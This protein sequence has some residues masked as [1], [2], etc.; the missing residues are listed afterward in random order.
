MRFRLMQ[1]KGCN[2][3][4]SIQILAEGFLDVVLPR[5]L[6]ISYKL[7]ICSCYLSFLTHLASS[8]FSLPVD[9]LTPAYAQVYKDHNHGTALSTHPGSQPPRAQTHAPRFVTVCAAAPRLPSAKPSNEG[10]CPREPV[11]DETGGGV[12]V[13]RLGD[14]KEITPLPQAK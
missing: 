4:G 7:N 9:F 1:G 8:A 11:R 3:Q 14:C 10:S 2:S 12:Q 13:G 6:C 5:C